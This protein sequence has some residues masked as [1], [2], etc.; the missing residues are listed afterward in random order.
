MM[1]PD[2]SQ[3]IVQIDAFTDRPFAGNPAAVCLLA[4]P[5]DRAW[6]QA[7]AMEK[8]L[9]ET[10][11]VQRRADGDFDLRWFTPGAE[12]DLCGHGTLAT[13]HLLWEQGQLR[14]NEPARFHTRS[15]LL[16]CVRDGAWIVM[17]FPALPATPVAMPAG[18]ARVL[19]AVPV[20]A[21]RSKWNLLLEL[22]REDELRA[23][24]P[25]FQGLTAFSDHGIIVT[26]P[27]SGGIDFVSRYFAPSIRVNED[28]VT[29]SAHC[30]LAPWWA[31]RLGKTRMLAFQA[32]ARGGTL[33]V[34]V[35][36]ERV[37]IAGQAVTVMEGRLL[38]PLRRPTTG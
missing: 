21:A 18:I 22:A 9:S 26:A 2:L 37:R 20:L 1:P 8:N 10:C 32:S 38:Q 6:M 4:A 13:A 17:D 29:G 23:M 12:V 25:D 7:V 16:T 34:E 14:G 24:A 3:P 28:P 31:A 30:T 27:A 15:G 36:G 33:R 5:R 19:G 11:F 35:T